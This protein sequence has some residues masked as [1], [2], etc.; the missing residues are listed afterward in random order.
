MVLLVVQA[1]A[2][3][4]VPKAVTAEQVQMVVRPSWE[5][6]SLRGCVQIAVVQPTLITPDGRGGLGG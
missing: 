1:R 3:A 4:I 5:Q 2:T 6:C